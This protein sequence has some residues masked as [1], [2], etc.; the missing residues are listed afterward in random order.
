MRLI[1]NLLPSI[2]GDVAR[3]N[4]NS[5]SY[6]WDWFQIYFPC[7]ISQVTGVNLHLKSYR[8]DRVQV[9]SSIRGHGTGVKLN[10]QILNMR[11]IWNLLPSIISHFIGAKLNLQ[12]VNMR[13][14]W[15]SWSC[16]RGLLNLQ[17]VNKRLIWKFT[18]HA[19]STILQA[20]AKFTIRK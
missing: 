9:N 4:L 10:L 20:K 7:I 17:I 6:R 2:I 12:I 18:S 14:I 3:I 11:L 13:L 19:L 16:Y 8:W 15:N 5:K 1:S